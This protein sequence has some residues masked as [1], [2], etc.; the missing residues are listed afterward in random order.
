MIVI[1]PKCPKTCL[2]PES[3]NLIRQYL[4]VWI[5]W[6]QVLV[7]MVTSAPLPLDLLGHCQGYFLGEGSAGTDGTSR[8]FGR[9]ERVKSGD[10]HFGQ[11]LAH[12]ILVALVQV[13]LC[14]VAAFVTI[15]AATPSLT[16]L[17]ILSQ[18]RTQ[19]VI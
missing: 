1:D 3:R 16:W 14:S 19:A 4:Y 5:F 10:G 6:G 2:T 11:G 17:V 13:R 18:A 8:L 15:L 9:L 12:L 7:G